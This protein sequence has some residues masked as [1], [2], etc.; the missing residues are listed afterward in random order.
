MENFWYTLFSLRWQ[1]VF[2]IA[3]NGYILFRFYILFRGTRSIRA[4][5]SI[6]LLWIFYRVAMAMGLI[7]TSW[8]I[9][10]VTALAALIIV[11]V[12]RSEFRTVFQAATFKNILWGIPRQAVNTPVDMVAAAAF[13]LAR[14]HIGALIVI[15]GRQSLEG[16]IQNGI[17]WQG[18]LSREMLVSIFWH[19][20][21]VHDGAVVVQ[22]EF[23]HE[24]GAIL[25]LSDRKDLPSYYGT[26]HR[27]AAGLTEQNDALVLVVSEERG[28][29]VAVKGARFQEVG[30]E[31][32]LR[33]V[34]TDHLGAEP[35]GE[36]AAR[37]EALRLGAAAALCLVFVSA[38]WF[39]IARGRDTL[40]NLRV[41]VEFLNRKPDMDL[42]QTSTGTVDL[43]LG[44]SEILM[45][46]LRAEQVRV[47]LDLSS[48]EP[49][50][51]S[52]QIRPENVTLP[53]GILLRKIEPPF[54]EVNLDRPTRKVV[55]IQADW[56]GRLVNHLAVTAVRLKPDRIELTGGKRVLE[57][58]STVYTEKIPLERIEKSGEVKTSLVINPPS[59]R[60]PP[61]FNGVVTVVYQ[62]AEREE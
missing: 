16:L 49:G 6:A 14:E 51:N 58:I 26:R 11:I 25:P 55:P 12:F 22:G 7:L 2:D 35:A 41:P 27:A 47:R 59:L 36:G 21:P 9:Q 34:I 15:P 56:T 42:Q 13:H 10:G 30:Q 5:V 20:T 48:A 29:V 62:V 33:R 3:L 44:G 24:V 43:Q 17:P 18:L 46:S 23:V 50:L 52:L 28:D 37:R 57:G 38:V 54:V 61:D 31:E 19:G 45:K 53:P 32:T 8:A 4:M 40:I 60:T 39:T 1:D